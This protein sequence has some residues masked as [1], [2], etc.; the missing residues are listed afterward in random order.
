MQMKLV[1]EDHVKIYFKLCPS[2]QY[3]YIRIARYL[4]IVIPLFILSQNCGCAK[5]HTEYVLNTEYK[6]KNI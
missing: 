1:L 2:P 6:R 3:T 5:F 4:A